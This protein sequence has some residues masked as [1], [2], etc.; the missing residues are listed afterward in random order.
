MKPTQVLPFLL[1]VLLSGILSCKKEPAANGS[2]DPGNPNNPG[3]AADTAGPLKAVAPF[4]FGIALDYAPFLND[5]TYRALVA[6][7]ADNVTFSYQMKHGA[8]VQD[9]GTFNYTGT[10]ALFQAATAAGLDVFGHTLVWHENQNNNYLYSIAPNPGGPAPVNLL[11]NGGFEAGSGSTF[12]SWTAYNSPAAFSSGTGAAEIHGGTRSLKVSVGA[13]NPGG[14]WRVQL[15]SDPVPTNVNTAYRVSFWIKSLAAGGSGRLSTQPTAQY[16]ADFE[17]GTDWT[18]V[19]WTFTARD[20]Q[21]RILLD[22]GA[23]ANTYL[24]DDVELVDAASGT[25]LTPLQIA[26]AVDTAMSRFIRSTVSRYA[27]RVKA[28]D[29]VNEPMS[30]NGALRA[31]TYSQ[32]TARKIFSWQ[33][34]L[35]RNYALK[36]FQYARAAD[37]AALLFINEY[38]LEEAINGRSKTDSLVAYVSALKAA[39]APIDGIGT[40]MHISIH[41]AQAA[42]DYAFQKL[43]AT[44][45][46]V[47]VSELDVRI[48]PTDSP[49]FAP[50]A[51]ALAR[52]SDMYRYVI[53][54]YML[55]VP[56]AQRHG[57]TIWG[58]SDRDSWVVL[59]QGK[60]DFPLLFDLNYARKPAY[61]GVLQALGG[62]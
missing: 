3:N 32:D 18:Q 20:A 17:T 57:V 25:S 39:G 14:Q 36:A 6:R 51:Q 29:V 27:G 55:H 54:S 12:T 50:T 59:V 61:Q 8:I 46:K 47:R 37:P 5:A 60:T 22:M 21:T 11:A 38:G 24:I 1:L 45:L 30:D 7:E 28:W 9:G 35:G 4:P 26:A 62:K 56:E 34:L 58:V 10:D 40:Q 16:Q 23:R 33:R 52:Q 2:P 41:T 43:A 15:A 49:G 13:D 31:S 42:I 48:N 19:T 53:R 44:G